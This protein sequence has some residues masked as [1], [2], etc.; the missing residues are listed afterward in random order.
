M[1][2]EIHVKRLDF[3][4]TGLYIT[5]ANSVIPISIY[6]GFLEY[7]A[8]LHLGVAGLANGKRNPFCFLGL[9]YEMV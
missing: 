6:N 4:R 2:K 7:V 8:V 9:N 1:Y 3:Y 5:T